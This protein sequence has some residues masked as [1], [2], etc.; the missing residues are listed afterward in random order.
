MDELGRVIGTLRLVAAALAAL[1]SLGCSQSDDKPCTTNAAC[2]GA[3]ICRQLSGT[4]SRM[5]AAPDA[6]N[7][8]S[9]CPDAGTQHPWECTNHWCVTAPCVRDSGCD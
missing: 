7:D 4:T 2:L 3:E 8:A 1:P 9:D 5:C 6:C